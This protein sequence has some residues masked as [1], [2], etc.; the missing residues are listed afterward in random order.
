MNFVIVG[1][2]FISIIILKTVRPYSYCIYKIRPMYVKAV[3]APD[4]EQ[5]RK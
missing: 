1:H 4:L 5:V 2:L 3:I